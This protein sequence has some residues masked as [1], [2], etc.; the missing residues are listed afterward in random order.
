MPEYRRDPGTGQLHYLEFGH[1]EP[2]LLLH[3]AGADA[4]LYMPLIAALSPHFRVLAPDLPGQGFSRQVLPTTTEAYLDLL[5]TFIHTHIQGPFRLIGHSLGGLLAALLWRRGLPIRSMVWMEAALFELRPLA[6]AL[7][8]LFARGYAQGVHRR[9]EV[10][11]FLRSLAWAPEQ[12]DPV[13]VAAFLEAFLRSSR[14]MQALWLREYPAFLPWQFETLTVPILCIRGQKETF[15]ARATSALAPRLPQ[16]RE[17][18]IPAAGHC[19][20]NENN[21][22]LLRQILA[23]FEVTPPVPAPLRA[24]RAEA[25]WA[26]SPL[27]VLHAL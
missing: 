13:R 3:G 14:Q 27:E 18:I 10:V 7:L 2:L 8:P 5:E 11:R 6:K 21:E 20:L 9:S 17:V 1:G 15:I 4:Q 16:A 26:G 22:E 12:A 25:V 19:L 24:P 23:H